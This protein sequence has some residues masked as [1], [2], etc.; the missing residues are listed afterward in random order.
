MSGDSA[1]GHMAKA[2]HMVWSGEEWL[3]QTLI[4]FFFLIFHG[5]FSLFFIELFI[6]L[7]SPPMIPHA[8]NLLRISCLF[9]LPM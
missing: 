1:G 8:H 6:F 9:Q 4:F 2:A 7:C 5:A 3:P